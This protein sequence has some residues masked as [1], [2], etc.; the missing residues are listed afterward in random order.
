[1]RVVALTLLL[2]LG[3]CITDR[4]LISNYYTRA[5][6]DALNAGT[7]CRA[8]ARNLLQIARCEVRR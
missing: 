1:M 7:Q 6:V 4:D 5:E 8:M 2:T 3:G